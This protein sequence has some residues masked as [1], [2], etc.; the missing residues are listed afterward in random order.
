MAYNTDVE[1]FHLYYIKKYQYRTMN[2]VYSHICG[3]NTFWSK[4]ILI[5]NGA[6]LSG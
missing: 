5:S 2:F 3:E 6:I 1:I 4:I